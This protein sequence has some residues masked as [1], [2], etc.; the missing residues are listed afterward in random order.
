MLPRRVT[1]NPIRGQAGHRRGTEPGEAATAG[2]SRENIVLT[3]ALSGTAE[4]AEEG[5][6]PDGGGTSTV[7]SKEAGQVCY[8]ITVTNIEAPTAA[9]IHKGRAGEAG[10][11]V[12]DLKPRF[13]AGAESDATG[14]VQAEDSLIDD[15]FANPA[16]YYLNVHTKQHPDGAVRGNLNVQTP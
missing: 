10:E 8:N 3:A 12:V 7:T 11:V 15:I 2:V 6:D 16:D 13:S 9:H 14:C 4:V 5:G 1:A